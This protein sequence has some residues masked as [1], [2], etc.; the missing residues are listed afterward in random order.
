[1]QD[2]PQILTAVD[3][4]NLAL[5][6]LLG[7]T[8]GYYGSIL[9]VTGNTSY[10]QNLAK[11]YLHSGLENIA[12]IKPEWGMSFNVT[13]VDLHIDWFTP[14]SFSSGEFSIKYDLAGL[15]LYGVTYS[16]ISRLNVQILES[17]SGDPARVSISKEENEP[18]TILSK[19]NFKF[20]R[21]LFQE[22]TW[23]LAAP[24]SEPV[25]FAN[26]T[27]S[28]VV[29]SGVDSST[30][31]IQVEDT[32]G[33]ITVASSFSHYTSTLNWNSASGIE[34]YVDDNSD[35]HSP[36]D[37]GTHSSFAAQQSADGTNDTLTEEIVFDPT[38]Y[39]TIAYDSQSSVYSGSS[40]TSSIQWSHNTGTGNDRVLLVAVDIF[41]D[42]GTPTTVTSVTYDGTALTEVTTAYY[43]GSSLRVRSYVFLLVNP[44]TG[45]KI[46]TANFAA[47]TRSI[48]G[49]VT[50]ANV[51]QTN[52]AL[53]NNVNTGAG[54]SMSV[55]LTASG[56]HNK[57]L[58][59]HLGTYRTGDYS[60]SEG[61]S[62]TNR[63]YAGSY[64]NYRKG[65][66]SDKTVTSG[67]VSMS[68]TTSGTASWAA[69]AVLLQP[70]QLYH[71][72]VNLEEQ[73]TNVS[74]VN[75]NQDLCIKTGPPGS[76]S[77]KVD[78]WHNGGWVTVSNGL[79]NG[80]N[81]VSVSSFLNPGFGIRFYGSSESGSDQT[82]NSWAIDAVLLR[83]QSDL[84]ALLSQQDSTTT[85]E[86]L[87]NGTIR[88]LGQNLLLATAEM[89]LPPIPAKAF[90]MNQTI[91]GIEREVAFQ[92]E[93]WASEY[94]VPLGLTSDYTVFS[95]RQMLVFLLNRD[96]SEF[97]L[98]WDGSDLA[99]QT[100]YSYTP[101]SFSDNPSG[102]TLNNGKLELH[103]G[104]GFTVTSTFGSTISTA[105]FMRINGYASNYGAGLAYVIYN[106]PVRDIVQ[107]EAEWGSSHL[108]NSCPNIYANMVLTLPAGTSYFTYQLRLMFL[109]SQRDRTITDLSP[110][111]LS[112]SITTLQTENGTINNIAVGTGSFSN[113]DYP[114]GWTAHH[115]S[116]FNG[117]NSA[118]TGIMFTDVANQRLYAF[119]AVAGSSTGAL[120]TSTSSR[121]IELAPIALHQVSPF[122][123]ALDVTWHGAVATF[124]ASATPIYKL[125]EA[126][127]PIGLWILVEF[128]PEI[129]VTA[130]K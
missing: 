51:N 79:V 54:T 27:Y 34:D 45:N 49:S 68:W 3:E 60:V 25:V 62:Q 73:W 44:S 98:W 85:V 83:P 57:R 55:G 52:P 39:N 17:I 67:S 126:G 106:A 124:D 66:G 42:A 12:D 61:G 71:Y 81:N 119:D 93:D 65:R 80:W 20:Y 38:Q 37:K 22:Q 103:F 100:P 19:Q 84:G 107:Q 11:N 1:M 77:L 86:W 130:E 117:T 96:V 105:N 16:T 56:T 58:Y 99:T 125:N 129:T 114:S 35:A 15:G 5:K 120:K 50:Y 128:Q 29:P 21:Y 112:S 47:S 7:F 101:G 75:P 53:A 30:Y 95:N 74:M 59:G 33:I 26:G 121:T 127:K 40:S 28:I 41:N 97:T 92:M 24:T 2:Q 91:G 23:E 109:N 78:V 14:S 89:P 13:S 70:T 113:N 31:L 122:R 115:W 123:D 108:A 43:S 63:W 116:Q 9:Q 76:E 104:S 64:S 36:P 72:E 118:G 8:V 102:G 87:Q 94:R 10:A 69:I 110:I 88:W 4:T 6:Q 111:Q 90:R 46:I 48:G 18:L 32:R 82:Q